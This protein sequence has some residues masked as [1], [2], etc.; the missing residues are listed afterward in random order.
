MS[1]RILL[2][3]LAIKLREN[4]IIYNLG[5][6]IFKRIRQKEKKDQIRNFHRYGEELLS[7][8]SLAC[9]NSNVLF[10]LD[11]GTLL[12]AVREHDFIKHDFDIDVAVH[13]EDREAFQSAIKGY[14]FSLAREFRILDGNNLIG[15]EQTYSY[16]KV[17][18]DI[19][20]YKQNTENS[21]ILDTFVPIQDDPSL[22]DKAEIKETIV[23]YYGLKPYLFK[24]IPVHI[25]KDE[26]SYLKFHYGENYMI[27]DP[28]Y[29]SSKIVKT[30]KYIDRKE[31]LAE[32]HQFRREYI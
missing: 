30:I 17:L 25:P 12:G 19:F 10:W 21:V 8:L 1:I 3:N 9:S 20:Y 15:L 16:K 29:D 6:P 18:I 5:R 14:G 24:G 2:Y 22:A 7:T 32:F 23:P 26:V 13:F 28:N 27:P 11:F 4:R 31:R